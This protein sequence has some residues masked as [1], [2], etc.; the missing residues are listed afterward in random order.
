M[1]VLK[2]VK[3]FGDAEY[4]DKREVARV[5]REAVHNRREFGRCGETCG[6]HTKPELRLFA[7]VRMSYHK[8]AIHKELLNLLPH[9]WKL[10]HPERALT[11]QEEKS[12][13]QCWL[14]H[15][16]S[17]EHSDYNYQV[18]SDRSLLAFFIFIFKYGSY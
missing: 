14:Q 1:Q 18:Y 16:G 15:I 17:T 13:S 5:L 11:K 9:K 3:G 7:T 2:A 12:S 8:R 10:Q 4:T 6:R